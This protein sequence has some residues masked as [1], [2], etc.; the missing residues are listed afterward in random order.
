MSGYM[1]LASAYPNS[2][3]SLGSMMAIAF[4][5]VATLACWLILV[6]VAAR[7]PGEQRGRQAH[8]DATPARPSELAARDSSA[9]DG[10]SEADSDHSAR[11]HW[12]AA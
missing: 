12:R 1:Y 3:L 5:A 9:E 2:A 7:E 8:R 11:R 6:F 10:H 4:V